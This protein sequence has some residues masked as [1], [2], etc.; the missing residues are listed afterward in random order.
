MVVKGMRMPRQMLIKSRNRIYGR[1]AHVTLP[2]E[3]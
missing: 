3:K 1:Y 2:F